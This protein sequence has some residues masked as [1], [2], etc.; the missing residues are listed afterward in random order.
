MGFAR[1][2]G[3]GLFV[4]LVA[5]L[6][7]S[8]ACQAKDQPATRTIVTGGYVMAPH[9]S[10]GSGLLEPSFGKSIAH[11]APIAAEHSDSVR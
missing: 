11:A 4:T 5:S 1:F 10:M 3:A 8:A 9:A 6:V 7:L 2:F